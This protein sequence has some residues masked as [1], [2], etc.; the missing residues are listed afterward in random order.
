MRE[1][2]HLLKP[3]GGERANT[4]SHSHHENLAPQSPHRQAWA[5][6]GPLA[7]WFIPGAAH[8]ALAAL[9]WWGIAAA[10]DGVTGSLSLESGDRAWAS[11]EWLIWAL[12]GGQDQIAVHRACGD[13]TLLAVVVKLWKPKSLARSCVFGEGG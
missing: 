5:L 8:P 9:G 12:V 11:V 3:C 2:S 4:F 10:A 13:G 1:S 6:R 7:W